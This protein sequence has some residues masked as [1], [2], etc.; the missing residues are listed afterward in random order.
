M[1]GLAC[2]MNFKFFGILQPHAFEKLSVLTESEKK[3]L[4]NWDTKFGHWAGGSAKYAEEMSEI[5]DEYEDGLI[6]LNK[7]FENCENAHFE[8]FRRLFEFQHQED[9]FV[10]NIHYTEAG[11]L[12]I[13]QNMLRFLE[14]SLAT[15]GPKPH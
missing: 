6:S 12:K 13:A 8:S 14:N 10:D 3:K 7:K 1:A 15:S 9:F 4:N 11:N 2:S 5:Y